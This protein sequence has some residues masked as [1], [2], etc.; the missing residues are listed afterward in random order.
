LLAA[1]CLLLPG[2][3]RPAEPPADD[4]SR[5]AEPKKVELPRLTNEELLKQA[6]GLYEKA[7]WD[8]LAQLRALAAAE[9]LLEEVRKQTDDLKVAPRPTGNPASRQPPGEEAARK[10]VDAASAQ[11]DAVRR[12]LKLVQTQKEL[13]DRVATVLEGCQLSAVAFQNALDDLKAYALESAL[14]VKDGSLAEEK[15][16]GRLKPDFLDKKQRELRDSLAG[17]KTKSAEVQKGQGA[18]VRLLE[19]ANKAGLAAD[20]EVVEASRNL[21][22]E[23]QRQEL[24]K[25]YAGKKPD[26][27]LAELS[28]MVEEGSGLKGAYELALRKFDARATEAARLRKELGALQ[29]PDVKV[30][31]LT[32]AEDM[33]TAAKSIQ[34]LI[35]FHAA[36]TKKIEELRTVLAALAREGG[37]FEADAA[38]SEEHLFKMQCLTDLLKKNGVA[39]DQLPEK[40]RAAALGP[41]AKRQKESA[42][43]VRAATEQAKAELVPLDRQRAESGA[44]REAA[45]KQLANLKESHDVTVAALKWEDRLKGMASPQVVEAFTATRKELADRLGQLKGEAEGYDKAAA[46][47]VEAKARLDGLKD[48]F[49]RAAEEQGQAEKQKLLGE[50]RKEAGLER[51]VQEATPPPPPPE[52]NR[53]EPGKKPEAETRTEREKVIDRLLAFQQLLAGR[54]RVLDER[55]VKK[56]ELLAVLDELEK[57]ATAYSKTLADARLLALQ[58]NATAVDLKKRLGMGELPGDAIPEGLTD[59]LRLEV[60]TKLDATAT[61]VLNTLNQLQQD[62]D[63]L[64]RPDPDGEALTAATKELLTVVG[65]RLDL[66]A[67]LKRLA[68]DDA[69]EKSARPPS[70][71][72]RLE[73]VAAERQEAESSGWDALLGLDTSKAAKNLSELLESY[74]RELIEIEEKEESLKKQREKVEQLLELTR[75]ETAALARV[76]PLLQRQ[77][78]QL[79]AARAEEAVLARARLRPERAEELL[80]AYQAKTGRLLAR[81]L[82][83]TDKEKAEKVEEMG[84]LLFERYVLLEAAKKWDDVLAARVAAAGV[85]AEAGVYQDELAQMAAASAANARR[86]QALTGRD[87]PGPA[88]GGEIVKTRRELAR[89]RTH[90]VLWIGLKLGGILLAA[91][92]LPWL[93]LG[94]LRRLLAR[95]GGEDSNLVL[96]AFGT[97]L[98][99]TAW[100]AAVALVLSVLGFDVTAIIAGLGIGGLAIGLAA[101]SVIADVIGALVIFAERRFKIGD[102]IR[103]EGGDPAR[104]VGLTWRSTQVKNVEDLVVT[105]PNRKVS[106]A[107]IQNLTRAGGTYD[108][109]TVSVT[110]HR[111]AGGVLAVIERAMAECE[112]VAPEHGV[113]VQEFNQK[114]ETKTIKYRFWWFLT[115]YEARNKTRDEVFARIS[116]SLAHED[117][118]G[119]EISLA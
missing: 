1:V 106:E 86:V 36:L 84:E 40:A 102:V 69:R 57:K 74:Y 27:L 71:I 30:P 115:D 108:S 10:A 70:E 49:L 100:V 97:I 2:W 111:D 82:P 5:P 43:A 93:L 75:Q 38:V 117:M 6:D 18:V 118:A 113:S 17:L 15:M 68:A 42:A 63:K 32:R 103:L 47:V 89:V 21:V 26:E 22:R 104:V 25:T 33:E 29:Q 45:A 58:L 83:L 52:P 65:R 88:T 119:T 46:A 7:S 73:Q 79:E 105:I 77:V 9:V 95:S 28:R 109:L 4:K 51:A 96:S 101:Q 44:A 72:K 110:T 94:I 81:P 92:L 31:R 53:A 76:L 41:A 16:P 80:K 34:G 20:A 35:G 90:G 48:P 8:Y 78:T 87:S 50:L 67:D 14:R 116:A 37:E 114:G 19:E 60:R 54:V 99:V 12:K 85:K 56:K 62:R 39:D 24:E 107:T 98:K 66:L 91:V 59:A 11:Q 61:A 3:G 112:H 64:L 23:Q 13:L 55:A